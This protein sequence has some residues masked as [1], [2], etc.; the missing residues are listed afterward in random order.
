LSACSFRFFARTAARDFPPAAARFDL[1]MP[2]Q[3]LVSVGAA[4]R[5]SAVTTIE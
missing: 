4:K 3:P 2:G 1:G 5:M